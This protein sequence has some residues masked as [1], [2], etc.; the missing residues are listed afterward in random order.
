MSTTRRPLATGPQSTP[1]AT[2]AAVPRA[3]TVAE[4]AAVQPPP[5]T[6]EYHQAPRGGRRQLGPGPASTA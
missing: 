3:G 1:L 6:A 4:R 2:D 5:T